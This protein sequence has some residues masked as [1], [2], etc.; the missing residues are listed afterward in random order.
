MGRVAARRALCA[1]VR[2]ER[3]VRSARRPHRGRLRGLLRPVVRALLDRRTR[4][5]EC[6]LGL[7]G[8]EVQ[9]GRQV[10]AV[11]GGTECPGSWCRPSPRG[12]VHSVRARSRVPPDRAMDK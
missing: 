11:A 8:Q 1:R 10:A 6:G 2:L 3:E 12:G 7:P 5:G 9:D 4:W